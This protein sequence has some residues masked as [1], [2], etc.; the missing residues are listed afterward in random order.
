MECFNFSTVVNKL[1]FEGQLIHNSPDFVNFNYFSLCFIILDS[2]LFMSLREWR[3]NQANIFICPNII[4]L[5]LR[6]LMKQFI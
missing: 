6:K 3:W 5:Y 4:F 1:K 2:N